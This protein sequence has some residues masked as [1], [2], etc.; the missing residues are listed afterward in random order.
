M[1]DQER[2][3]EAEED[4]GVEDAGTRI[5]ADTGPDRA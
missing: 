1:Q 4:V 3:P 2:T 5:S